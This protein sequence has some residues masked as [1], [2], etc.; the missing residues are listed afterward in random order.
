MSDLSPLENAMDV[1][2]DITRA[3][4]LDG[5]P[6]V[7]HKSVENISLMPAFLR[8]KSTISALRNWAMNRLAAAAKNT[9][10]F[11]SAVMTKALC[12]TIYLNFCYNAVLCQA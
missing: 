8:E 3:L 6:P 2:I 10:F 7:F 12:C 1:Q 11:K 5:I 9:V 4:W